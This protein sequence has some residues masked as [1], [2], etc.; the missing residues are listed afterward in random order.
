MDAELRADGPRC[1]REAPAEGRSAIGPLC[2]SLRPLR[3]GVKCL[4]ALR[5]LANHTDR[6][7]RQKPPNSQPPV[8]LLLFGSHKWLSVEF[9]PRSINS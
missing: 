2:A 8:S 7:R 5:H 1:A 9:T 6:T 3:L 4:R